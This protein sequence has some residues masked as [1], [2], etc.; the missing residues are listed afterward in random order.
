[1]KKVIL[2]TRDTSRWPEFAGSTWVRL[3]YMLGL[4]KLGVECFWVDRLSAVDPLTHPHTL[5]YLIERFDR[6]ARQFGFENRYC[7]VY[8]GGEKYFG[9]SEGHLKNLIASTEL[10]LNISGHLP[11]DSP[12][13]Q[14][15][16]RAYV[17]V[18]PGF[19]QIW[20]AQYDMGLDRHNF[21]FTVGQNVG[22]P[23]FKIPS[24][25]LNWQPMLP[26]VV[27]DQ[28]P[29]R[30]DP[31]CK[32]IGTVGDWRGNQHAILEGEYYGGKRREYVELL[33]LPKA[34]GQSIELAL[35]IG[36]EDWED[37]GLLHASRW[38]VL[39]SFLYAGDPRSYREFI[40][41]SRA[42]F[43]VAKSGYVKSNSGWISDR[44]ACYLASGKP[45]LVQ[46]TGYE[47]KFPEQ[48]GLLTFHNEEE[49]IAGLRAINDNYLAHSHAARRLV[50]EFFDSSKVIGSVLSHVGL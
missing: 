33:H 45:A 44:T 28:W 6:T 34:S 18:D 13:L 30:V 26:P 37:I 40:Q 39:D 48:K 27:L 11:S 3:Q 42:E 12:L 38:K 14:V 15:P 5:E 22:T 2:G 9:L 41:H 49:A 16:R 50:E 46:S 25:G 43:S 36:T 47:W 10:L 7:I 29:A 24:A 23:H 35:C 1:M 31:N 19:T 21:F 20:S 17:D 32:R 4:T 8:N